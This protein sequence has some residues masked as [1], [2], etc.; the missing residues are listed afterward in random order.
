MDV[1]KVFSNE[2]HGLKLAPSQLAIDFSNECIAK[3]NIF[4]YTLQALA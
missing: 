1:Y 3:R 2:S 4:L